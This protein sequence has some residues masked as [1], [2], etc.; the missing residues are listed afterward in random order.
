MAWLLRRLPVFGLPGDGSYKLQPVYV[1]DLAELA[2][3]VGYKNENALLQ[4]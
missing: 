4:T 2:V 1:D 3:E